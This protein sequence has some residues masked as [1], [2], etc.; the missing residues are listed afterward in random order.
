VNITR[1][2]DYST[3]AAAAAAAAA[4]SPRHPLDH[5]DKQEFK[6]TPGK[7]LLEPPA[8]NSKLNEDYR[9][10]SDCYYE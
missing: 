8:L 9:C 2:A 3:A 10:I 7:G 4:A 6:L 1:I 5:H